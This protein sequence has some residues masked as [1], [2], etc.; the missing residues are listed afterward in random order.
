MK[1]IVD[2]DVSEGD[3]PAQAIASVILLSI[4]ILVSVL[5][6]VSG[7]G[8]A[9]IDFSCFWG[10][11]AMALDGHA[12]TAYDWEQ[13]H[14][15]I[16]LRMQPM[17][18]VSYPYDQVPVPFFY[19][20]V[21]FFVLAPLAL[22][23]FPIAFWVWSA[24]K[25]FCWLLVVYA[26]RPRSAALLLALAFPPI[27]YDFIAGQSGLLAASLLGGILLTLNKRPLVSGFL[28]ALLIFKPQYGI[29]LPF[30]LVATGRWSVVITAVLVMPALVLLTGF[31]FGWDTFKAF[32]AAATF[33]TTQFHLSG[34][35][36]WFK[37]QSIYGLFRLAGFGYGSALSFHIAIASAAAIWVLV[38]WR[39][40]VSFAVQAA[41]LLAATPL[42][43]P[44]FAI[45]D[46][47][48]LAI[49]LVF[50]MN[51][52]TDQ[53]S[54]LS[55]RRRAF[56]IGVTIMFLLGYAFPFVLVPV[57]PFMCAT[58][59]VIIWMRLRQ[60]EASGIIISEQPRQP[61]TVRGH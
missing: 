10:A 48:I 9:G 37:L 41:S 5:V 60:L 7:G 38:I 19:P 29:L 35:L 36:P 2:W 45:Y 27:L 4:T 57:G 6:F 52:T 13:L 23:P 40:N 28:L 12:A 43:S 25:L 56:R 42:I 50:L 26:I 24:A 20:P 55:N 16:V 33:A 8:Q 11:G 17:N 46:L 39:R 54:P 59:I 61:A 44:Y 3:D 21:F 14:Q 58:M 49:A 47:P 31:S 15:Q 53:I 34:A 18:H 22:L 51:A 32:G 1:K 30:V